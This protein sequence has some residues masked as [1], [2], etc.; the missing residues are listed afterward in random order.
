MN[1]NARMAPG[2]PDSPK[3]VEPTDQPPPGAP[4]V[5]LFQTLKQSAWKEN[6]TVSEIGKVRRTPAFRFW[7][8]GPRKPYG[9]V[10]AT[11]PI[12]Y[13]WMPATVEISLGA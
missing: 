12:K 6:A 9:A 5:C 7:L 1:S 2:V 3:V 8:P 11:L 10:R 13:W 4:H